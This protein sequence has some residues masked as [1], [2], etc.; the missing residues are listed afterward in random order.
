[1]L[2]ALIHVVHDLET[3]LSSGA[4]RLQ[5]IEAVSEK[6][7][8]VS[9]PSI[10]MSVDIKSKTIVFGGQLIRFSHASAETGTTMTCAVFLPTTTATSIPYLMFLSGLTCTDENVCQKSGIFRSLA[11]HQVLLVTPSS[12][13]SICSFAF[14]L[15]RL[16]SLHQIPLHVGRASM[17]RMIA[18]TL[19]PGRG[20]T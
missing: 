1:M 11:Q 10:I 19:E 16:P 7:W 5:S 8:S 3:T 12:I 20:S 15:C 2:P 18:G 9:N 4:L 13:L 14:K 6:F 17:A